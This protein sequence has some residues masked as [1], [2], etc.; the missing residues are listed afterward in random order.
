M[1]KLLFWES[2]LSLLSKLFDEVINHGDV[3]GAV[4]LKY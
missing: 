1:F 2:F 3:A 4:L